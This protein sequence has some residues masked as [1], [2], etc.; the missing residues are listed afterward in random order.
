MWSMAQIK[1]DPAPLQGKELGRWIH[2]WEAGPGEQLGHLQ[3]IGL[4]PG[5]C[6]GEAGWGETCHPLAVWASL[7]EGCCRKAE[8]R[9][10]QGPYS[11][12]SLYQIP[13]D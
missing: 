7:L 4:W 8:V 9:S 2:G 12:L 3:G 13:V 1:H 6:P 11:L 10:F 5:R